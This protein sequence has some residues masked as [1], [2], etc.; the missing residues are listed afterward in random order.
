[1]RALPHTRPSLLAV[2]LAGALAGAARAAQPAV[3]LERM[4]H[5]LT[6][7]D[8]EGTFAHWQS[9]RLQMLR[10]IHRIKNG[11]VAERLESLDGSGRELIRTGTR[12]TCYLP[13]QHEVL[14]EHV[15]RDSSLLASLPVYDRHIARFYVIH[16]GPRVR[17]DRHATRLITVMPRDRY[18]YGYRL[19][20]DHA[21]MPLKIQLWNV[22]HG[23][24]VVEQIAFATLT[25]EPHIPNSA[26]MPHLSTAGY[27]WLRNRA[28][29]PSSG[30][31][32]WGAAWLPPGFHMATHVVQVMPGVPGSVDHLVY[33]DGLASVSVFVQ[34]HAAPRAAHPV[35]EAA[36]MG[37][38]YVF[39]TIVDGHRVTAVGQ[40]PALTVRSIAAS[41]RAVP[42]AGTDPTP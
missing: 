13:D 26:F 18:R 32:A 27:R 28:A 35:I 39:S 7:L 15:P 1:M 8:Y 30:G 9:G 29:P 37:A 33:T 2:A 22:R 34:R 12:L 31:L 25:I 38:S 41:V 19:W 23:G 17:V 36:R 40:A 21:G 16:A 42:P 24:R 20:I 11:V 14:V 4:N 10:I 5:A 3:W 6:H